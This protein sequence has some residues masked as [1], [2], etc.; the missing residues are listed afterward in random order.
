MLMLTENLQA[1]TF[2][3]F[4]QDNQLCCLEEYKG[5]RVLLYFYPKDN[6]PGCTTQAK[7]FSGLKADFEAHNTVVLGVSK[8]SVASHKSFCDK[9]ALSINLLADESLDTLKAYG[10]W[11]EKKNYGKTYMGIVRSSVLIDTDGTIIK[12]WNNVKAAGHA[13]KVLE[14]VANL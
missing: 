1:P 10:V 9:Q 6:T 11:Q 3:L 5:K 4:N 8:D 12:R 7:E 14:T 13:Q 2:K